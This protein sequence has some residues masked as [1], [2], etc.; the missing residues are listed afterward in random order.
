[1][2]FAFGDE[3]F[4]TDPVCSLWYANCFAAIMNL[5]SKPVAAFAL[6]LALLA[7]QAHAGPI[8]ITGHDPDYHSQEPS[9]GAQ[10]FLSTALNY[11]MGGKL[12]DNIHKFLWVE[13]SSAP[14]GGHVTGYNSLG[15]LGLTAGQDYDVVDAVGLATAVFTNYTAIAVASS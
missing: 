5:F 6:V 15:L 8:F 2:A 7:T 10:N 11:V 14:L 12:N 4:S 13:S 1:M 9:A 3:L